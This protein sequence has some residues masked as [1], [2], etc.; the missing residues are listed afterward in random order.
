M[1][2]LTIDDHGQTHIAPENSTI[3]LNTGNRCLCGVI[4]EGLNCDYCRRHHWDCFWDAVNFELLTD[5]VFYK[6][7]KSKK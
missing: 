5:I 6:K 7:I 4:T 2:H 3:P 1:N